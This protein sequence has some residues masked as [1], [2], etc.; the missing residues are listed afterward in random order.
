METPLEATHRHAERG[1]RIVDQLELIVSELRR[2]GQ[3]SAMAAE[4]L[5]ATRA[6]LME[7][8]QDAARF[9]GAET[10]QQQHLHGRITLA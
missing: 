6:L 3:D 2:T 7:M 9:E 10:E 5:S 4:L 8:H 1:Q